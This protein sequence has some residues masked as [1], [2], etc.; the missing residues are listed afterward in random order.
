MRA[1]E[2]KNKKKKAKNEY[3]ATIM[4]SRGEG[5]TCKRG[6]KKLLSNNSNEDKEG[7]EGNIL[8]YQRENEQPAV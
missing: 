5:A 7:I 2:E 8:N 3:N 1:D 4:P 6:A